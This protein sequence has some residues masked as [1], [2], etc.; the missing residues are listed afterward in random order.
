[1]LRILAR[2][3]LLGN[4]WRCADVLSKLASG[5]SAES[6]WVLLREAYALAKAIASSRQRLG[7]LECC[8]TARLGSGLEPDV[9]RIYGGVPIGDLCCAACADVPPEEEYL[10]AVGEVVERGLLARAVALAQT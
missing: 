8:V 2:A 3:Y 6:A 5:P 1:M 7:D 4:C 10:E 9:C